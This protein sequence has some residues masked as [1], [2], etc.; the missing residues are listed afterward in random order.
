M[1]PREQERYLYLVLQFS[2]TILITL[3]LSLSFL[4]NNPL[5][6]SLMSVRY[7]FLCASVNARWGQK[8]RTEDN[9]GVIPNGPV[10]AWEQIVFLSAGGPCPGLHYLH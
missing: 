9:E 2:S 6:L 8:D 4:G 5:G 1:W 7:C 3:I 10:L